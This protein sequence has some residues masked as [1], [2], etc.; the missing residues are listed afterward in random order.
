M[1]E[2]LVLLA[3]APL[4]GEVKTRLQ[5]ALSAEEA[6]ALYVNFL[7]D[8][9]ALME[10]V[11]AER[12]ELQL[13]LCYTPE[14][15]EEAFEDV[16]REGSLMLPQRGADL[17]ERLQHC[18]AELFALGFASVVAI[19]ADSPTLPGEN[20]YDAFEALVEED[21]V[22]L[23]PTDDGGYYLIGMRQMYNGLFQGIPWSSAEVLNTTIKRAEAAEVDVL[24][25]P[26]WYDVDT[27]A[28][29]ARLQEEVRENKNAA[30]F[31][32]RFLKNLAK[33]RQAN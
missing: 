6:K 8:T 15:A 30:R 10:D 27:P 22:V 28:A 23:G 11:R 20:V 18:F 32:R 4:T 12:D 19:G 5:G 29:L 3:K 26:E 14:G 1:K 9:F 21:A 31:T 16:E 7:N 17:G 25:L 33:Q 2:A 24:L 13:V